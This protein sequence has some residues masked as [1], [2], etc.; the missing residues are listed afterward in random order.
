M[1]TLS[2]VITN[3]NSKDFVLSCIESI[4]KHNRQQV[5]SGDFE[6]IVV[7]NASS[8]GS[9]ESL[10]K[11]QS[12]TLIPNDRN[13]GFSKANNLGVKKANGRYILFLNPDTEVFKDTLLKMIKFMDAHIDV[14]ASTCRLLLPNG[15]IDDA[16]HRG[17]P[18]PWNSFMRFSGLSMLFPKSRLLNG[19][20]LGFCDLD[21]NHEIDVLAGAFMMVRRQAGEDIGWWDEDYFFYGEDIEFCFDLKEKGWKIYYVSDASSLHHKGISGGIKSISQKKTTA[22]RDTK[23]NATRWR[24]KAMNIFYDKHYVNRYPFFL[25]ALVKLAIAIKLRTSLRRIRK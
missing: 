9:L 16:S 14:G 11:L 2:V 13:L 8:D 17:F 18:T 4:K 24:Y 20:N 21:K 10:S 7:D 23:L 22:D 25:S 19:Y 15:K 6:I 3:Y 1:K 12:I 5:E